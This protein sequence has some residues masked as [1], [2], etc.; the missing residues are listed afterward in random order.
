MNVNTEVYPSLAEG[1]GLE[2]R[3]GSQ[4]PLPPPLFFKLTTAHKL[5]IVKLVAYATSLFLLLRKLFK[6]LFKKSD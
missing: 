2:N 3:Q 4:I 6:R 1:I 5:E